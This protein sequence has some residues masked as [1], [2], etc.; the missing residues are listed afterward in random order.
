MVGISIQPTR[1]V[2]EGHLCLNGQ[3]TPQR[4]P[5]RCFE[6]H[7]FFG[8]WV[9]GLADRDPPLHLPPLARAVPNDRKTLIPIINGFL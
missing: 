8:L 1:I 5:I 6:S 7:S 9:K 4:F 2:V 3:Y